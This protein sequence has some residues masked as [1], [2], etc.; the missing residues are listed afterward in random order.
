MSYIFKRIAIF[1]ILVSLLIQCG[2]TNNNFEVVAPPVN[3]FPLPE[4]YKE[5]EVIQGEFI[6][7]KNFRGNKKG[8][9]LIVTSDAQTIKGFSIGEKGLVTYV[10]RGTTY[11]FEAELISCPQEGS[12]DFIAQISGDLKEIPEDFPGKFAIV[13][14]RADDALLISKNAVFPISEN[15]GI[16]LQLDT[17]GTLVEKTIVIGQVNETYYQVLDGINVGEK[18]VLR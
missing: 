1:L 8:D 7:E 11:E 3:D 12:G 5:V 4:E 16:V 13:V 15:S 6:V 2:C 9:K 18:V 17:N 10:Y 14:F